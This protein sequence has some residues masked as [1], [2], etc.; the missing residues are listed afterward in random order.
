LRSSGGRP[1]TMCKTGK[2]LLLVSVVTTEPKPTKSYGGEAAASGFDLA[3]RAARG[4]DLLS[5]RLA[6]ALCSAA[7]RSAA[8]FDKRSARRRAIF[9]LLA[10]R[11]SST[12]RFRCDGFFISAPFRPDLADHLRAFREAT[13]SRPL[14]LSRGASPAT[15]AGRTAAF[16]TGFGC[17][18]F[19][20][21]RFDRFC[22]FAIANSGV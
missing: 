10:D 19:F 17:F 5:T 20:A 16:G 18:G 1:A 2:H 4:L 9:S 11:A 13:R 8:S 14:P 12:G 3:P 22:A 7:S 6:A 15:S 21:S